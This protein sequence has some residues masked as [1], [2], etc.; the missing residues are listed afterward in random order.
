MGADCCQLQGC[1]RQD[2]GGLPSTDRDAS[3]CCSAPVHRALHAWGRRSDS[4]VPR[5]DRPAAEVHR[6]I[7]AI[8]HQ[9]ADANLI[10]FACV[11][12]VHSAFVLRFQGVQLLDRSGGH[13]AHW[14]YA[15][16]VPPLWLNFLDRSQRN[17]GNGLH[18]RICSK[19]KFVALRPGQQWQAE[20][21]FFHHAVQRHRA[22][23]KSLQDC[24]PQLSCPRRCKSCTDSG[25]R[26]TGKHC[27]RS[28]RGK[29]FGP[30]FPVTG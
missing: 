10:C 19:N 30:S 20:F 22:P 9:E 24:N 26:H 8:A 12:P 18:F 16:S 2:E 15:C 27:L 14:S 1:T 7:V 13:C 6:Q 25:H 4:C 11:V 29:E 23:L 28:S 17:F 3:C 5:R 21:L